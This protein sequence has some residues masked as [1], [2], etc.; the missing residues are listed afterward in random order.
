[1]NLTLIF[2]VM[3]VDITIPHDDNLVNTEKEKL[4]KHLDL[5]HEVTAMWDVDSTI[6]VPIIVSAGRLS[7]GPDAEDGDPR[8]GTHCAE[9]PQPPQLFL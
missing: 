6:V 7:Q 8:H 5:A 3:L 4:S 2:R 9:V 1:M